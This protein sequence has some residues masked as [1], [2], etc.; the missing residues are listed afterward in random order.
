MMEDVTP[1]E[2]SLIMT[3]SSAEI[4]CTEYFTN[5]SLEAQ[6]V[7]KSDINL[8]QNWMST[9]DDALKEWDT[10]GLLKPGSF[11]GRMFSMFSCSLLPVSPL[12][13]G[14]VQLS[15]KCTFPNMLW[16]KTG[17]QIV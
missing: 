17:L 16:V 5:V 2:S 15:L 12:H 1:C 10:K 14:D 3:A 8:A 9:W 4:T 7:T 13:A 11:I 6:P